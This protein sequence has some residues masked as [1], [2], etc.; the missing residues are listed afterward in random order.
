MPVLSP[1]SPK[2][3]EFV[4]PTGASQTTRLHLSISSKAEKPFSS[5]TKL[6]T[7][8]LQATVAFEAE[9]MNT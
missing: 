3:M 9:V 1:M 4:L 8:Q 7:G 5:W 6:S 2:R